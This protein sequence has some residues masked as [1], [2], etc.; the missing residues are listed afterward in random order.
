MTAIWD[1]G[2]D[3]VVHAAAEVGGSGGEGDDDGFG[4]FAEEAE[5]EVF[6][7][8]FQ[9]SASGRRDKSRRGTRGCVRHRMAEAR[10]G[11]RAAMAMTGV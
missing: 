3:F 6:E 7:G 5:E 8:L 9:R 1:Q 10:R 11:Q 2:A 4:V